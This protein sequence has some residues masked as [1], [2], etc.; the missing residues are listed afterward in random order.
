WAAKEGRAR[1]VMFGAPEEALLATAIAEASGEPVVNLCGKTGIRELQWLL[2][3]CTVFL[4]NDTGTMHMAA[5]LGTPVVALF[6]PTSHESFGPL[7]DLNHTLQ[8]KASCSPCFP[9][10]TCDMRGCLA[11]E[12]ITSQ[13]VIVCLTSILAVRKGGILLPISSV[14]V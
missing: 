5:A 7:G 3:K 12:N 11:M 6:G 1:V 13:Q 2:R 14:G 4:S 8:G 9:H 10:P